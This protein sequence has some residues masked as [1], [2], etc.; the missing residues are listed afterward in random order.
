MPDPTI[1]TLRHDRLPRGVPERRGVGLP[2]ENLGPDPK[3][4]P[5]QCERSSG[6]TEPC[7]DPAAGARMEDR[8]DGERRGAR[9]EREAEHP[10]ATAVFDSRLETPCLCAPAQQA[11]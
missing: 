5:H 10:R 9:E 2:E 6:P 7:G 1:R 4:D 8:G 3:R 11:L